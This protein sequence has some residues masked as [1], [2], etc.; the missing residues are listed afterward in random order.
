MRV[1]ASLTACAVLTLLPAAAAVSATGSAPSSPSA[2]AA[3]A[4]QVAIVQA[5]PGASVEVAIDGELVESGVAAGE[6]LGPYPLSPGNH[7]VDFT[8]PDGLDEAS[9]LEVAAGTNQDLVLHLPA[10]VDGEAVVSTYQTPA[11]PIGPGKARVLVAHTAT[12]APADVRVDGTVVFSNIANGEFATADVPAGEHVVAL[13]PT[14]QDTDPILGPLT[15]TLASRT[16]TMV[17]AIGNPDDGS[18]SLVSH[19]AALAP[20]GSV[21]PTKIDTGSA[22]LAADIRVTPFGGPLS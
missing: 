19:A 4:G 8:G 11:E 6:V 17:Y 18:M 16:V 21:V 3:A 5:V 7:Q 22:G 9:T 12:V 14:G 2:P 1:S 15:V 13:L 20:D 10:T